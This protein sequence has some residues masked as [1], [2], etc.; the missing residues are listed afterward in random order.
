MAN[1]HPLLV[2][3]DVPEP[4]PQFGRLM[5]PLDGTK[6]DL[7]NSNNIWQEPA[8]LTMMLAPL[9][10]TPS[11]RTSYSGSYA[12]YQKTDYTLTTAA[13]WKQM[14]IRASGDYYLQSLDVTER[15]TLTTAFSANQPVYLSLYVPGLK[16]T[17]KSIILKAGWGV[18][19]AGS[20]EV[21]FAANGSAQVY[22]SGVLGGS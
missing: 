7:T 22:K 17:D 10:V 11:W 4:R 3:F 8:T 16:D 1:I 12:R 20:V 5:V 2:E 6:V 15:A 14:Q 18:G 9:P 13:K 21:W 19:S